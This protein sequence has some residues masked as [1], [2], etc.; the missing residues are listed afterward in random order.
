MIFPGSPQNLVNG[1]QAWYGDG[2]PTLASD[3]FFQQ[4]D[5]LYINVPAAS[6]PIAPV[7]LRCIQS[8]PGG[9]AAWASDAGTGNM[10]LLQEGPFNANS[11][12]TA[13]PVPP[14][15]WQVISVTAVATTPGGAGATVDVEH[16]TGTALPGAGTAQLTAALA[17]GT[18]YV[19][20]TLLTGAVIATPDTIIGPA[21]RIGIDLAGTLTGLTGLVVAVTL[22]QTG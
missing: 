17:V 7:L 16:L 22:K 14:G 4:G 19:G 5:L 11:V 15:H 13:F 2:I 20:G 12:S 21:D 8:G 6:N 18:G 3:G 1:Y 10:L 9:T